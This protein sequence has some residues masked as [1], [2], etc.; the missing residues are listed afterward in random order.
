MSDDKTPFKAHKFVLGQFMPEM[1]TLFLN[2]PHE[3]PIIY[4]KGVNQQEL[5]TI[6]QFIYAGR[7]EV[8]ETKLKVL[9]RV[10]KDLKLNQLSEVLANIRNAKCIVDE[11]KPE[12]E[13]DTDSY[14]QTENS[15]FFRSEM[16]NY[17]CNECDY[18]TTREMELSFHI[19]SVHKQETVKISQQTSEIMLNDNIHE[20]ATYPCNYSNYKNVK[21]DIL[22]LHQESK[23]VKYKCKECK[24]ISKRKSEL[25]RHQESAHNGVKYSCDQCNYKASKR[26]NLK[27]HQETLHEG[28]RHFCNLCFY[29]TARK[30]RLAHHKLRKHG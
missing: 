9:E 14:L 13:E 21:S 4:L 7:V 18:S 11:V 5:Q 6:L 10:A 16:L 30:D 1:K 17:D 2:N 22:K 15:L 8:P 19:Q 12:K 3:H 26:G 24:F 20:G 27:R 28:L 25:K 23:H 29:H